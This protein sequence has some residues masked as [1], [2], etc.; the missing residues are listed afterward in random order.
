MNKHPCGYG[1]LAPFCSPSRGQEP[2]GRRWCVHP[3]VQECGWY[4][5]LR[6][7]HS[8]PYP[9]SQGGSSFLPTS[10]DQNS[11]HLQAGKGQH[12]QSQT[13]ALAPELL[14]WL[15]SSLSFAASGFPGC[16]ISRMANMV[17]PATARIGTRGPIQAGAASQ[18]DE[19]RGS[20]TAASHSPGATRMPMAP[21]QGL[22]LPPA[23][24]THEVQQL[25]PQDHAAVG[26]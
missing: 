7:A 6:G 17:H 2:P 24:L 18:Q 11:G 21:T 5:H 4:L 13:T 23:A 25:F 15:N 3:W 19:T 26:R 8:T 9:L 14:R 12:G 20:D 16:G 10:W 22:L 1:S